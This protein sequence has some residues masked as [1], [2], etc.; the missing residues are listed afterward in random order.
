MNEAPDAEPEKTA[1]VQEETSMQ[2]DDDV[3]ILLTESITPDLVV[4]AD[5]TGWHLAPHRGNTLAQRVMVGLSA[6]GEMLPLQFVFKGKIDKV[7][8]SKHSHY[9]AV[10]DWLFSTNSDT[11]WAN[12]DTMKEWVGKVLHPYFCQKLMEKHLVESYR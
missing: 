3:C 9:T 12:L 2:E 5:Q 6:S 7:K 10:H 11:H 4:N 1:P 8:G